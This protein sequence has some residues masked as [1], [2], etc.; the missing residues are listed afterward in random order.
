[1]SRTVWNGWHRELGRS[2]TRFF[3]ALA[4]GDRKALAQLAPD[5]AV[6]AKLPSGLSPEAVCDSQNPDT[7]GTAVVAGAAPLPDGRRAPWSLWW[8][9]GPSG[10]R[11][12][13]AAPVLQ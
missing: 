6:R 9:R 13:G 12:T 8:T 7:P 10:W 2:T 11:L 5:V 1:M 3:S 4:S